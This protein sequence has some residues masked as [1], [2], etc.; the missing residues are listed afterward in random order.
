M[1]DLAR[2][3]M[4]EYMPHENFAMD[5]ASVHDG[6]YYIIECGCLNSVGLYHCD[7]NKLFKS[8]VKWMQKKQL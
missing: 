6:E 4:A 1:L 5:I 2:A 3:R 7:I 8:I